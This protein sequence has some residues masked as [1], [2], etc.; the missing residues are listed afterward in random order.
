MTLYH[1]TAERF[2]PAI[3]RE[4]LT[5]G[6]VLV[7]DNPVQLRPG[8]RW[9][10]VNP[11]WEQDWAEGTGRLPYKRNEVRLTVAVPPSKEANVRNWLLA[12]PFLSRMYDVLSEYGDPHNWRLYEGDIPPSWITAVDHNPALAA[13][14]A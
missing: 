13:K 11:E 5:K 6:F 2:L 4:G 9:L 1:F 3:R 7:W 14:S 12:G 8:Y 10:T